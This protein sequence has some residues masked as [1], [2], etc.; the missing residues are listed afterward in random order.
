MSIASKLKGFFTPNQQE[1]STST[2]N[3]TLD[4]ILDSVA[5]GA[6]VD[7]FGQ[8][9][10]GFKD[11][12]NASLGFPTYLRVI[13][14]LSAV[15][16]ELI[17]NGSLRVYDREGNIVKTERIEN[18]LRLFEHSPDGITPAQTWM[19]DWCIDYLI[20]GNAICEVS[21]DMYARNRPVVGLNRLSVW[22]AN[23]VQDPKSDGVVYE[24]RY[25]GRT[26][27]SQITSIPENRVMHARW[28]RTLRTST[29]SQA[30]RWG[31]APAPVRLMR[32]ALEVGL[33]SDSY[34]KEFYQEANRSSV[35]I[36]LEE[37]QNLQDL[38]AIAQT[39]AAAAKN[40]KPMVLPGKGSFT[41]LSNSASNE[42]LEKLRQF[43]ITE[44]ARVYGIPGPVIGQQVTQWGQGIEQLSK[45]FWS[46]C[47]RQHIMRMLAPVKF[48]LL[49]P[50]HFISVDPTD[51]IRGDITALASLITATRRDAQSDQI[52][53]VPETRR[54]IGVSRN[55][56][57]G[58][59]LEK[60]SGQ[61]KEK[62]GN[63][64]KQTNNTMEE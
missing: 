37:S 34:I 1:E 7:Y 31:F 18:L 64:N 51:L 26:R 24:A 16:S 8:F 27:T 54:L 61:M 13:T 55:P 49:K 19:E 57:N 4:S 29:S 2:G 6:Y 38:A 5:G 50:G 36:S 33:A 35:G 9:G 60:A 42:D 56:Q 59:K 41:N 47:V 32:L 62:D 3:P 52:L 58:E 21:R 53:T 15:M 10:F 20:D 12:R 28:P 43:Q 45:M 23:T 40:R 17:T 11:I 44:I 25:V 48:H 39:L 22:D 46:Q 30:N 63:D 14:I